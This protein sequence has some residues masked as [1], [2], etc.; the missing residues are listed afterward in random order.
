MPFNILDI[1]KQNSRKDNVDSPS[2][3]FA[4]DSYDINFSIN[5]FQS[6][7]GSNS[8]G[9]RD[10]DRYIIDNPYNLHV[11]F[12][13]SVDPTSGLYLLCG[14]TLGT[15]D[16]V[17]CIDYYDR[18]DRGCTYEL[19]LDADLSE[20]ANDSTGTNGVI[21]F[22]N[23]D[24]T[25][26][27]FDGI[28][29]SKIGSGSGITFNTYISSS[30]PSSAQVGELWLDQDT[31]NFYI[32]F[33][34][35]DSKQWVQLGGDAGPVGPTGADGTG[36]GDVIYS[37]GGTGS[38][39]G[40]IENCANKKYYIDPYISNEKTL[41]RFYGV[42]EDGG[43]SASLVGSGTTIGTYNISNSVINTSLSTVLESGSTLDLVLYN[44]SGPTGCQDFR[45]HVGYTQ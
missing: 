8:P 24:K 31:G 2:F 17:Q 21:V 27:G 15:G 32:F 20:T 36:Q 28:T 26:Y 44:V 30:G 29:W 12:G 1:V 22:N 7:L 14:I 43:C 3:F 40:H 34:D 38:Y 4:L 35:G 11:D 45:F 42:C 23:F 6:Q 5:S 33:D 39:Q 41:I 13:A 37:G 10:F 9:D 16:I 25:F 18:K 19:V